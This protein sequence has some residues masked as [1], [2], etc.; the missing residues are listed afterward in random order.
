MKLEQIPVS[1]IEIKRNIVRFSTPIVFETSEI[2]E[3][4]QSGFDT[5]RKII[6]TEV[7]TLGKMKTEANAQIYSFDKAKHRS[8][9]MSYLT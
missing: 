2:K 7:K 9:S 1:E 5:Y 6:N 8:Y 3:L 4:V